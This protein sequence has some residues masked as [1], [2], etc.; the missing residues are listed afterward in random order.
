LRYHS[1]DYAF[2][3]S[4]H[5]PCVVLKLTEHKINAASLSISTAHRPLLTWAIGDQ[6]CGTIDLCHSNRIRNA[7]DDDLLSRPAVATNKL[8]CV[9]SKGKEIL[10][11]AKSE[12]E[13]RRIMQ[14]LDLI[15]NWISEVGVS[16]AVTNPKPKITKYDI[17]HLT[18]TNNK[19]LGINPPC[20]SSKYESFM[21][22]AAS[23]GSEDEILPHSIGHSSNFLPLETDGSSHKAGHDAHFRRTQEYVFKSDLLAVSKMGGVYVKYLRLKL[24]FL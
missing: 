10:F 4:K 11:E 16:T 18:N 14:G 22:T 1:N 20:Y 3:Q 6:H 17:S 24:K 19:L 12:K 13:K 9:S 15:F 8:F 2:S 23:T 5:P 7:T 21:Y